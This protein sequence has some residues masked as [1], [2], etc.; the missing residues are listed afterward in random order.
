MRH[1][2]AGWR[3]IQT[4]RD[5]VPIGYVDITLFGLAIKGCCGIA[6][7]EPAISRKTPTLFSLRHARCRT[8]LWLR[9][10]ITILGMQF[11]HSPPVD[12]GFV[13]ITLVSGRNLMGKN[14][15]GTSDP[16][17]IVEVDSQV[18][19]SNIKKATCDPSWNETYVFHI[20]TPLP[21]PFYLN[22]SVWNQPKFSNG[23]DSKGAFLGQ[24]RIDLGQVGRSESNGRSFELEKRS[25]RSHVSGTL[26]IKISITSEEDARRIKQQEKDR[27]SAVQQ[28]L[29][30]QQDD[31]KNAL[32]AERV[33]MA[34][35]EVSQH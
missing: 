23:R 10:S 33:R 26:E 9:K 20:P 4:D 3:V 21:S 30:K 18:H 28:A 13:T 31:E 27:A 34:H 1:P 35:S 14:S 5:G 24:L 7:S 15:G 8:F 12:S 16:F 11:S 6:L 32:I 29:Q 25:A 17:C 2:H 22:I 19:F